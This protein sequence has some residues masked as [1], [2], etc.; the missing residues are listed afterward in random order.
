MKKLLSI[1]AYLW[2]VACFLII[3]VTFVKN[4]A[5]AEQLTRLSFMKVHPVYSGGVLNQQ[6]E[7]DGILISINHPVGTTLFNNGKKGMV[8]VKFASTG[9]LPEL[10][11]QVIDY[12]F[13]NIPDFKVI[14]NT[15]NGETTFN[16][17][18]ST[19]S[20]LRASSQVKENW[21]IRLNLA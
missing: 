9:V 3:P 13:D 21:V 6:Y 19:A 15:L 1:P 10:I 7:K 18:N 11:E 14:I 20:S 5:F 8:Q 17:L 2:A 4:D 12:N 16:S